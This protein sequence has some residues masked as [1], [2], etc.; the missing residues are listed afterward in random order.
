M[1]S[2]FIST[3]TG[4]GRGYTTELTYI[5]GK[6]YAVIFLSPDC[7]VGGYTAVRV[8]VS[9]L[10]FTTRYGTLHKVSTQSQS[11]LSLTYSNDASTHMNVL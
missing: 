7:P 11:L 10:F 9:E 5:A 4:D 1:A 6:H 8:R 3:V 2:L